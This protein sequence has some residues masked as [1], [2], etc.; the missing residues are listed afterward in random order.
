MSDRLHGVILLTGGLG[1]IGSHV[2]AEITDAGGQVVIAD[3]VSTGTIDRAE[4]APLLQID[5]ADSTQRDRLV[6]FMRE[7]GVTSV[8]H[9]AGRKSAPESVTRPAWYFQQNIGALACVLEAMSLAEVGNLVFSSSAAVYGPTQG[10]PVTEQHPLAPA[11]PYGTTKAVCEQLVQAAVA[12]GLRATSLRYFN[13]V[14]ASSAVRSEPDG[15]NLVPTVLTALTRGVAVQVFGDT[16]PTVDGTCVRDYVHVV[17]L[18]KAHV[19]A[20]NA[21]AGTAPLAPAY[22]IGTGRGHSVLEVLTE[23]EQVLGRPVDRIIQ[24]PRVGDPGDVVAAVA[25]ATAEL[26]WVAQR[27]LTAMLS[28]AVEYGPPSWRALR[29]AL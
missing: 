15:G 8:V 7:Y 21:V 25:L 1:Y 3:D 4:G 9:L 19:S 28:D 24:P 12:Q 5:L 27:D 18:A 2:A 11:N 13:V 22:N 16:Y 14:G 6:Q 20:L 23:L 26:G 10:A 17:D 29:A